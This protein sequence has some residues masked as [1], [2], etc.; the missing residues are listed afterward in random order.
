M[1]VSG[2]VEETQILCEFTIELLFFDAKARKIVYFLLKQGDL[3]PIGSISNC[4][5]ESSRF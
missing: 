5:P 3:N 4:E 1:K 2:Y